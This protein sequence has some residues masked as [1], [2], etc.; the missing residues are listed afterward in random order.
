MFDSL[1]MKNYGKRLKSIRSNLNMTQKQVAIKGMINVDTLR[2]IENGYTIVKFETLLS[3]SEVYKV[4]LINELSR[5]KNDLNLSY[6]YTILDHAILKENTREIETLIDRL[7]SSKINESILSKKNILQFEMLIKAI[8]L[9]YNGS[10]TDISKALEHTTNALKLSN[11]EF[12]YTEFKKFSYSFIEIRLLFVLATL[13]GDKRECDT[14]N[15]I[16]E[17]ILNTLDQSIFATKNEESLT[18]K[19]FALL[20]YNNHRLNQHNAAIT[21]ALKGIEYAIN[22]NNL[23]SLAYLYFRLGVARFLSNTTNYIEPLENSIYLLRS[24][25]NSMMEQHY[26]AVLQSKYEIDI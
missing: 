26:R 9:R 2:K 4:D 19:S 3:L 17:Y 25:N 23:E 7:K 14:S 11:L 21:Q 12:S 18:L 15:E 24:C 5:Y 6:I 22:K 1:D 20:S 10:N 16:I 13:L 8:N